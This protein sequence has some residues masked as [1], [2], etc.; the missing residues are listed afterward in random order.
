MTT[1]AHTSLRWLL[2]RRL[3]ALQALV[4]AILTVVWI[5]GLWAGGFV[6][7]GCGRAR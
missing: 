4:L 6:V 2:V 3:V 7:P 5:G 1:A